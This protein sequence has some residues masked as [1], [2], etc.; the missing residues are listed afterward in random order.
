MCKINTYAVKLR[1]MQL[2]MSRYYIKC[3]RFIIG[4]KLTLK[5]GDISLFGELSI[6]QKEEDSLLLDSCLHF[7][8]ILLLDPLPL[9]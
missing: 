5:S 1:E 3:S 4:S 8:C 9:Q 6:P 2:Y 7:L